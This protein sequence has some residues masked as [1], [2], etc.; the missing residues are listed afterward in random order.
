M[1]NL[2][3]ILRNFTRIIRV[4]LT[5]VWWIMFYSRGLAETFAACT[6]RFSLF[7]LC[8]GF[9][10]ETVWQQTVVHVRFWKRFPNPKCYLWMIVFVKR[11]TVSLWVASLKAR[12]TRVFLRDLSLNFIKVND[13]KIKWVDRM[14]SDLN[15]FDRVVKIIIAYLSYSDQVR[16]IKKQFPTAQKQKYI[17]NYKQ[18]S[19]YCSM[20]KVIYIYIYF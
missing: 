18:I 3:T 19:I 14:F 2:C 13:K 9:P 16:N 4:R 11:S 15:L 6:W 20:L 1:Y 7:F 5:T 17:V 10:C 12:R 8:K